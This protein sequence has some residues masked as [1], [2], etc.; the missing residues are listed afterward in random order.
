MN[1]SE[2]LN[3]IEVA[4]IQELENNRKVVKI[5]DNLQILLIKINDKIFAIEDRCTHQERPLSDGKIIDSKTIECKY[6]GA[7]FDLETGKAI[8]MPA[9]SSINTFKTKIENQKIFILLDE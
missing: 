8:K 3:W 5:K 1:N 6:H 2:K 9:V 7:R 4:T